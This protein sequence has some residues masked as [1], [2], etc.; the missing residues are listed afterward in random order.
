M[1]KN[2]LSFGFRLIM[3]LTMFILG[4]LVYPYLPD[5]IPVHWNIHGEVDGYGSKFLGVWLMPMIALGIFL[6]FPFLPKIDPRTQHF[7]EFKPVWNLIQTIL[8]GFMAYIYAITLGAV[9]SKGLV[10]PV[11][12]FVL[13]GLG[14][15]FILLGWIMPKIHSNYFVGFRTPWALED[16]VVWQKTQ[17]FAG[18]MFMLSGL[19]LVGFMWFS[20]YFLPVF[21]GMLVL[22]VFVPA[23]YS[24]LI[25]KKRNG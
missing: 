14:V 19:L 6:L 1:T 4:F 10:T 9:L 22:L 2:Q 11:T 12:A 25:F 17:A 13:L 24:Y 18:K 15:L 16:P 7:D 8:I 21:I 20:D 3:V 5:S 23:V